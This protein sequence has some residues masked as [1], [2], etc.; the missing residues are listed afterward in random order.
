MSAPVTVG[1]LVGHSTRL[2][3]EMPKAEA[4][5]WDYPTNPIL[6]RFV[7]HGYRD[8]GERIEWCTLSKGPSANDAVDKAAMLFG[9]QR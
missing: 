9:R 8:V 6:E 3:R 4:E 5:I 1:R 2:D 7:V